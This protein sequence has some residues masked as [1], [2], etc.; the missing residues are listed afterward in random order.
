MMAVGLDMGSSRIVVA[1]AKKGGVEILCNES[2]YRATPCVVGF[3]DQRLVGNMAVNKIKKNF[4]NSVRYP[5]RFL[6]PR[7]NQIGLEREFS[8]S[9]AK[10]DQKTGHQE[11]VFKV[12]LNREQKEY[13]ARQIAAGLFT[14][15]KD[16]LVSNDSTVKDVVVSVPSYFTQIE[17]EAVLEA[18]KIAG[19]NVERLYNES[20]ANVMNYGIFRKKDLSDDNPRIVGFVDVGHS[21]S[22]VFF[23]KIWKNKAEILFEKNLLTVGTRNFDLNLLNLYLDKFEQQ[24][25]LDDHRDSPK[26]KI[27][28]LAAIEKQRKVLSANTEAP[29]NVEYLFEDYDF[30]FNLSREEFETLNQAHINSIRNLLLQGLTESKISLNSLH[31]VEIIGGGSRMPCVQSMISEILGKPVSK[32]LD[33]NE[34]ISRG[35]AIKAAMISPLF[36][37]LDYDIRDRSHYAVK[38]GIKYLGDEQETVKTVFKEGSKFDNV[39][40]MTI[41][42]DE[43]VEVR[44]F[45]ED[46]YD[47]DN[48]VLISTAA[49]PPCKAKSK[50]FKCKLYFVLDKNGI[51]SI[52][53]YE[54]NEKEIVQIPPESG[55]I[56]EEKTETSKKGEKI[57]EEGKEKKE[58]EIKTKEVVKVRQIDFNSLEYLK[59]S[60]EDFKKMLDEEQNIEN[61]RQILIQT[62]RAMNELESFI[63]S[64]TD[65]ANQSQNAMFMMEPEKQNILTAC[66]EKES[67][68]YDDG[69]NAKMKDYQDQ[70]L[71][72]ESIASCL[73][74]RKR[75]FEQILGFVDNAKNGFSNFES[76]NAQTWPLLKEEEKER[77]KKNVQKGS[78]MVGDMFLVK[79]NPGPQTLD[80]YNFEENSKKINKLYSDCLEVLDTANKRE[81]KR[82][83]KIE[84]EKKKKEREEKEKAE[85][86]KK[87][88]EEKA[89]KIKEEGGTDGPEKI[90]EETS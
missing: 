50:D 37:V 38:V 54:V 4:K 12:N 70:K 23:A 43:S 14:K 74:S 73:Y 44:L 61:Q 45:Y 76:Q 66:T 60:P 39:V 79:N 64:T 46:K 31:S 65:M 7:M 85:K 83:K 19:L 40:S 20:T 52:M 56:E 86:E 57:V 36:K 33:A 35:C 55:K 5:L 27:R 24:Y 89:E 48:L 30:N 90:E 81:Q 18:G 29:I 34:S 84:E 25:N 67:W 47:S 11:M 26:V 41:N 72:L 32:T 63:Y 16:I 58:E 78:E 13:S 80:G 75:K 62:Q 22:S 42:R 49:L 15:V 6:T 77:I 88:K 10:I 87:E 8:F 51:A 1:V 69:Q 53:K 82:L 3:G 71:N 17:R 2:S 9:R 21:K 59:S 28:L 68:L